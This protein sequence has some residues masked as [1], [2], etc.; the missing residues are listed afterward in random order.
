MDTKIQ[1]EYSQNI[2]SLCIP[3]LKKLTDE[4]FQE[5]TIDSQCE[6]VGKGLSGYVFKIPN[7]PGSQK[8]EQY[9]VKVYSRGKLSFINELSMFAYMDSLKI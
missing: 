4:N 3:Y 5:I 9:V 1:Q 6:L 2:L 8:D 7:F